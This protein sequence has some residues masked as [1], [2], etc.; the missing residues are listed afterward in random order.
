[1][2]GT[3]NV[4]LTRAETGKGK[5]TCRDLPSQNHVYGKELPP[6]EFGVKESKNYQVSDLKFMIKDMERDLLRLN[7]QMRILFME[8]RVKFVFLLKPS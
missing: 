7:F 6:M 3:K 8:R 1:M 5:P 4:L 2:N